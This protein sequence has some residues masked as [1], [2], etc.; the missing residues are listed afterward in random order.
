MAISILDNSL[1]P[2][3]MGYSTCEDIQP[4]EVSVTL[5]VPYSFQII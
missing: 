2:Y 1:D 3:I 4:E 5:K